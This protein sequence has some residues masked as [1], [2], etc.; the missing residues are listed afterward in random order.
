MPLAFTFGTFIV[1][2]SRWSTPEKEGF[3]ILESVKRFPYLLFRPQ[4]L[5]LY[6]DHKNLIF[7]FHPHMASPPVVKHK[8]TKIE[9]WAMRLSGF[10]Y[11][12]VHIL[13]EDNSWADLLSRLGAKHD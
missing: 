8:V 7:I 3:A 9:R 5:F 6:T 11:T 1:Y 2:Y 10:R 4:G 13:G 12:M